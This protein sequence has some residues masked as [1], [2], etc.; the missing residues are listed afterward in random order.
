MAASASVF[1]RKD[2]DHKYSLLFSRDE[3]ESK[4]ALM[5]REKKLD[6]FGDWYMKILPNAICKGSGKEKVAYL[7]PGGREISEG[8]LENLKKKVESTVEAYATEMARHYAGF[9]HD[10]SKASAKRQAEEKLS[11]TP[12]RDRVKSMIEE[13][14]GSYGLSWFSPSEGDVSEVLELVNKGASLS[15]AV[16]SVL[17]DIRTSIAIES[18]DQTM[19]RD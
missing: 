6:G 16:T 9:V 19:E 13:R 14:K 5:V 2:S 10:F 11:S 4:V 1:W 17:V 15:S 8:E 3:E 18:E 7:C 12:L